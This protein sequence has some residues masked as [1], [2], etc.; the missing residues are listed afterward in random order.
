MHWDGNARAASSPMTVEDSGRSRLT[1]AACQL[2]TRMQEL[3]E[4][5][6]ERLKRWERQVNQK[7]PERKEALFER[8]ILH[9]CVVNMMSL[10]EKRAKSNT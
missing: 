1:A 4:H 5:D 2:A 10:M 7:L 8:G 6:W 3:I 9:V